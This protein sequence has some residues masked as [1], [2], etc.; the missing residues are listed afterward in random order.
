M[1]A[2]VL[3]SLLA[4]TTPAEG[5]VD[6][7][8]PIDE[9]AADPSFAAFRDEL[10]NAVARRDRD[11]IL[12]AIADDI[13]TSFGGDGGRAEFVDTWALD[14]PAESLI[15]AELSALLALGCADAGEGRYAAPSLYRQLDDQGDASQALLA[16]R[17]G[18]RLYA[19]PDAGSPVVAELHWDVLTPRQVAGSDDWW[20]VS[21]ADGR[22]GFVRRGDVRGLLDYRAIFAKVD[23]RW[24]IAVLVVG[25]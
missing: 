1:I 19:R 14:A 3:L 23:G 20:P 7:R 6:R 15:W 12:S 16:I 9:C 8:P 4:M 2:I 18:A 24:R 22:E 13:V 25:D 10:N 21:L 17:P 5:R 11:F